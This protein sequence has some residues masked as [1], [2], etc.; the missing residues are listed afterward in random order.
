[1][2]SNSEWKGKTGGGWFGQN[3]LL[4]VLSKVRVVWLY[5][6]LYSQAWI[7]GL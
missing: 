5:P 2:Q 1:M 7:V 6:V 3:F 4:L